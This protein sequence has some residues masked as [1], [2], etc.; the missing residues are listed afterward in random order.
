MSQLLAGYRPAST[1]D[2]TGY[3]A[4]LS[5]SLMSDC[6]FSTCTDL[7]GV[8]TT[9]ARFVIGAERGVR[10]VDVSSGVATSRDAAED[11]DAHRLPGRER[12][13]AMRGIK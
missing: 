10:P 11:S 2:T 9:L 8:V 4:C 6:V 7:L 12:P 5:N 1:F 13:Y 3:T